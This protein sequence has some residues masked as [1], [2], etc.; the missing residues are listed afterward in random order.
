MVENQKLT[1]HFS[2]YELTR[3]DNAKLQEANRT[4]TPEQVVKLISLAHW[5]ETGPRTVVGAMLSH[6]GYR[7]D[8][9]NGS[10]PGHSTTS[11]HVKC[12]ALDFHCPGE[13]V[14]VTFKKLWDAAKAKKFAFGQ[15]IL[16]KD[17]TTG[18]QWVHIS[19]VG[20]LNPNHVGQVMTM[21][22]S[23]EGRKYEILER[24]KQGA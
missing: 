3:T 17:L 6:S 16:E 2:L 5:L 19:C 4:L 22:K 14:D 11:Q 12:E 24:I 15:L 9:L 8:A 23:H 10:L 21:T 7:C 1:E 18:A 20:T 13:T